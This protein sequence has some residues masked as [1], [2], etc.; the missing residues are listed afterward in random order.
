M[1]ATDTQ[2]LTTT[3]RDSHR[4]A[5]V[6]LLVALVVLFTPVSVQAVN[7]KT[8]YRWHLSFVKAWG[9]LGYMPQPLP[10][11]LY[12]ILLLTVHTFL[13]VSYETVAIIVNVG[14]YVALGAIL[15][16]IFLNVLHDVDT[17]LATWLSAGL[18][19]CF[20]LVASVSIPTWYTQNL[21]FG[22]ILAHVYHNPT[23][24]LLKPLALLQF[25]YVT[26][27]FDPKHKAD[28]GVIITLFTISAL[29]ALAKPSLLIAFLP[30]L[31]V[32]CAYRLIRRQHI[33]WR[34]LILG[35]LV[36]SGVVLIYQYL[37]F[38]AN[39]GGIEFAPFKSMSVYSDDLLLKFALSII[40]PVVVYGLHL[41]SAYKYAYLNLAWLIFLAGTFYTYF[42]NETYEPLSGNFFWSA[43]IGLFILFMASFIFWLQK[44]QI[45]GK[46][47][48]R[49]Y[50][51]S[52]AL[53]LHVVC[54]VLWYYVHASGLVDFNRQLWLGHGWW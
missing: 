36:P 39:M 54:G 17:L 22:Y 3:R 34:L 41:G 19:M 11:A 46:H 7:L 53:G 49:L 33:D 12:H 30:A 2:T 28:N 47:D 5:F 40:F 16:W 18:T 24:T 14:L 51:T 26:K 10:H 32:F 52:A 43:Q 6:V 4:S 27:V 35:M 31:G 50:L 8:D 15:Y 29:A 13:P 9:A 48:I 42:L 37:F 44:W 20:L 25:I 21:Y 38:T 1:A 23:M 45:S